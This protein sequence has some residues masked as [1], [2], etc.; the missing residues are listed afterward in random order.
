MSSQETSADET[1]RRGFSVPNKVPKGIR[2][3]KMFKEFTSGEETSVSDQGLSPEALL[4]YLITMYR[5]TLKQILIDDILHYY[6][7]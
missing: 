2:R 4:Y 1:R 5:I 3:R 7:L 6:T